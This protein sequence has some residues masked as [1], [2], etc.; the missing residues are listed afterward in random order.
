MRVGIA[1]LTLILAF[2]VGAQLHLF[3]FPQKVN[4][5]EQ[6]E[7]KGILH[8]VQDVIEKRYYDPNFHGFDLRARFAEA[9]KKID[10]APNLLAGLGAVEWA[11]EG[12]NDSHTLFIPP[13]RNVIVDSG[14]QMEMVGDQ[15]LITA[16]QPGSD[17]FKQGLRPGDEVVRVGEYQP[18]R[19]TYAKI[20][21][22]LSV[23]APLAEYHFTVASPGQT[24]RQL[25]TKSR[26]ETLPQTINGFRSGDA[27]HQLRRLRQGYSILARSRAERL[28]DSVLAWKLPQFNL[29]PGEIETHIDSAKKYST[30]VFDLRENQGGNEESLRWLVGAFFDH[31]INVADILSRKGKEPLR[32]PTRGG[33]AFT[34]KLIVLVNSR[35]AS[36]AEIFARVVQLEKRGTVVGEQTSGEVGRAEV[37]PLQEGGNTIITY[38]VEVTVG[39]LLLSDGADLE[40]T[41]VTPD[42]KSIPTQEDLA[43]NRDPVLAAAAQL[44]G[45]SLTPDQ[46]GK[47]FPT[48]WLTH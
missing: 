21:Y 6:A 19:A 45:V 47:L 43:N 25:T 17:A 48:L 16:V 20:S 37:V 29:S 23:V 41:G 44:A 13:F 31:D 3:A 14:W 38:G 4:K 5:I 11:V 27:Q 35:S 33:K 22:R 18:N 15:C 1:A 8:Q 28:S 36:A 32:I 46:A 9:E 7:A 42:I 12:L 39:R 2:P 10:A 24:A 34:G 30:L 26:L 40:G